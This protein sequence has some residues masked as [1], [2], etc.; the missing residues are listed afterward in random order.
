[1]YRRI[2]FDKN[3][4]QPRHDLNN[5]ADIASLA[6]IAFCSRNAQLRECP[7]LELKIKDK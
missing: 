3:L 7:V 4:V 5:V 2:I 1:M 6:V